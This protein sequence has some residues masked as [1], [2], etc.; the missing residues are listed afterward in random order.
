MPLSVRL[1]L[2]IELATWQTSSLETIAAPLWSEKH[3]YSYGL[4][5][6]RA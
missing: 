5:E 4:S 6:E 2:R 1:S 3:N